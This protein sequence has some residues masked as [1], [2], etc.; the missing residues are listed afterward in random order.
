MPADDAVLRAARNAFLVLLVALVAV[1]VYQF[2]TVGA[3]RPEITGLW[4]GGVVVYMG[5]K[6]FYS[7][8]AET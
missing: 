3:I 2:A 4:L 8:Q 6:W 5:S 7:R 1:G